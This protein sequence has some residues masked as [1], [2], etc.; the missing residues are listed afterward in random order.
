MPVKIKFAHQ[1]AAKYKQNGGKCE[2]KLQQNFYIPNS[3][4]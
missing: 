1:M 4:N 2:I 3:Q